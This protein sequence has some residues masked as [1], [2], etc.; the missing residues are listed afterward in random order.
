M[1]LVHILQLISV[2]SVVLPLLAGA[3]VRNIIWYYVLLSAICDVLPIIPELKAYRHAYGNIFLLGEFILIGLYFIREL[4]P[5]QQR[6]KVLLCLGIITGGF[7]VAACNS[8]FFGTNYKGG[9]LLYTVLI[10]LPLIGF[11]R[12]IRTDQPVMILGHP[13]FI[14]C[15]GFFLYITGSFLLMLY[16]TQLH[17][18]DRDLS[19]KLWSVHNVLNIVKNIS[20]AYYFRLAGKATPGIELPD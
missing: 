11:Y 18:M 14:F 10:P 1:S 16:M 3:R 13:F 17:D 19:I 12:I 9:A 7:L 15:A 5:G 2:V 4:I 20:I 6:G 8:G